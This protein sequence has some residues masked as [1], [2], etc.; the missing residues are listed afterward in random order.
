M[1]LE[2]AT[3]RLSNITSRSGHKNGEAWTVYEFNVEGFR[4]PLTT[5]NKDLVDMTMQGKLV[6]VSYN[7]VERPVVDKQTGMEVPGKAWK[8]YYLENIIVVEGDTGTLD[9]VLAPQ[10]EGPTDAIGGAPEKSDVPAG[11]VVYAN[12]NGDDRQN[13]IRAAVALKAAVDFAN[14]KIAAGLEQDESNILE[15]TKNF[16]AILETV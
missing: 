7:V 10:V 6:Q 13:E 11:Q 2:T 3:A 1:P 12:G 9:D 5:F 8:N 4:K 14:G 15:Y 16:K